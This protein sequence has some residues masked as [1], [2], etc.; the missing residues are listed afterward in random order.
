[1]KTQILFKL[2]NKKGEY[3]SPRA[4][5]RGWNSEGKFLTKR[6]LSQIPKDIKKGAAVEM[7]E[8]HLLTSDFSGEF[9]PE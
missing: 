2:R 1:M 3:Y 5:Y 9:T 7:W 4:T 6:A 8:A